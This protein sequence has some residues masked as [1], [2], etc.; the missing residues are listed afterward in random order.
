[1]SKLTD[2]QE[3]FCREYMVDFNGTQAAIRAGYAKSGAR[4]EG[5]RL[6]ANANIQKY[7]KL[8]KDKQAE[9]TGITAERVA[10]ELAKIGFSDKATDKPYKVSALDKLG[11]ITGAYETHNKQKTEIEVVKRI[12]ND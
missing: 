3:S 12:V 1:M 11:K 9:K 7:L 8:L 4:T 10:Q 6:L 2:K 5:A